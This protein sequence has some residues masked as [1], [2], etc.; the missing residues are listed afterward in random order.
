[1]PTPTAAGGI[2]LGAVAL[3]LSGILFMTVLVQFGVTH[4]PVHRSAVIA[5]IEL[6]A[7]AVS[8]QLLTDEV[9]RPIEWAG[10][11]LIIAGAWLAARAAVAPAAAPQSVT[12]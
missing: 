3:G 11:A 1:V 6:V 12:V 10:G 5:L 7:G 8:Q 9:V 2:Y 4:L